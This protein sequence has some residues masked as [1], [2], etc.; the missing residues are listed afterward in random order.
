[1]SKYSRE[2][3]KLAAEHNRSVVNGK[4][5]LKLK[6]DRGVFTTVFVSKSPSDHRALRNIEA[7]LNKPRRRDDI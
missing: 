1:M 3:E 5:H 6:C 4:T 7:Q 2:I